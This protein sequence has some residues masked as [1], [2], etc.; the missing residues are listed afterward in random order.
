MKC[1]SKTH[2]WFSRPPPALSQTHALPHTAVE[3][4][5]SSI[6]RKSQGSVGVSYTYNL[7]L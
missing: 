5:S 4:P 6:M 3:L 2:L 1:P 7:T